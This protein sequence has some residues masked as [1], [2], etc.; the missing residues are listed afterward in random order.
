MGF[1]SSAE[2][3]QD[4]TNENEIRNSSMPMG[5]TTQLNVRR[6][7]FTNKN[8]ISDFKS[9]KQKIDHYLEKCLHLKEKN[10]SSKNND[11]LGYTEI[12]TQNKYCSFGMTTFS[13]SMEVID[14]LEKNR[15]IINNIENYN[16]NNKKI[17]KELYFQYKKFKDEFMT[18]IISNNKQL[19]NLIE[20]NL[21]YLCHKNRKNIL[22]IRNLP[23]KYSYFNKD[24]F[25]INLREDRKKSSINQDRKKS[26]NNDEKDSNEEK[27]REHLKDGISPLEFYNCVKNGFDLA[28][29]K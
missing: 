22:I 5:A 20:N 29:G 12:S 9:K 27:V 8:Q 26:L 23:K 3:D 10:K 15:S 7:V 6:R 14:F 21:F 4:Q 18:L 24:I 2:S 19:E 11:F 25:D 1:Y 13:L 17:A 28:A 16:S